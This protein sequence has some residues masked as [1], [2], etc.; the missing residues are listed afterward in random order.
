MGKGW[1]PDGWLSDTH[2]KVLRSMSF[3]KWGVVP[4]SV[5]KVLYYKLDFDVTTLDLWH[6]MWGWEVRGIYK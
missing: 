4:Q 1:H 5:S 6:F 2:L 3:A